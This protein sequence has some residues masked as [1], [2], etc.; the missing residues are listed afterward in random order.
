MV[1]LLPELYHVLAQ[2]VEAEKVAP[3]TQPRFLT[4][5]FRWFGRSLYLLGQLL[6]EGL[7]S[8]GISTRWDA[9]YIGRQR[10]TG[11]NRAAGGR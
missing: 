3:H 4:K 2:N 8:I 5:I 9:T 6:G 7:L 10:G 1:C 11:T